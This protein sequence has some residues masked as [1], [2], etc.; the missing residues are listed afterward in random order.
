[1]K[2]EVRALVKLKDNYDLNIITESLKNKLNTIGW[3]IDE[4]TFQYKAKVYDRLQGFNQSDFLDSFEYTI[5]KV[6]NKSDW[7]PVSNESMAMS[8]ITSVANETNLF[9]N[10]GIDYKFI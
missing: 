8:T 2:I 9:E 5:F 1:M 3:D 10:F 7:L 4:N 6:S